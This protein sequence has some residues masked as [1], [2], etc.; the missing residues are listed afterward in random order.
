MN[1]VDYEELEDWK[2]CYEVGFAFKAKLNGA[3]T[4]AVRSNSYMNESRGISIVYTDRNKIDTKPV[5]VSVNV[6]RANIGEGQNTQ[7]R[8]ESLKSIALV[9]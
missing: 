1:N 2:T 7:G 4:F 8:M 6:S 9:R 5:I 3:I